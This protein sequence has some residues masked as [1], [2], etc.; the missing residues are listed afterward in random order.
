M[1]AGGRWKRRARSRRRGRD[2]RQLERP[3]LRPSSSTLS[4]S[5][6]G[7]EPTMED[8][9]GGASPTLGGGR[10]RRGAAG[11]AAGAA[12]AN[13]RPEI[14]RRPAI[15]SRPQLLEEGAAVAGDDGASPAR[16]A[17]SGSAPR[18]HC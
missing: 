18:F 17:P 6:L 3:V 10:R 2:S 11:A 13:R 14:R 7:P 1:E 4:G 12:E 9:G 5:S 8:G 16:R 15:P